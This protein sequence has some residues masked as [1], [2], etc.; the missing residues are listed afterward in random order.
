[1]SDLAQVSEQETS[2]EIDTHPSVAPSLGA[3]LSAARKEKNW[4]VEY[5]ADHL[6][7]S[8]KQIVSIE[9]DNFAQL[10]T[11]VIVRGFIRSYAKMLKLDVEQLLVMLPGDG[12]SVAMDVPLRPKLSTP[13]VESRSN[14]LGRDEHNRLYTLGIIAIALVL[15]VF[16]AWFYQVQ[17]KAKINE[18]FPALGIESAASLAKVDE[19]AL[20]DNLSKLDTNAQQNAQQNSQL[21][22][23]LGASASSSSV[24]NSVASSLPAVAL[25]SGASAPLESIASRASDKITPASTPASTAPLAPAV[26]QVASNVVNNV[27][28]NT[29]SKSLATEAQNVGNTGDAINSASGVLSLKV[30]QDSWLQVK[31]EKGVILFSRLAK[32][33]TQESFPLNVP[34]LVKIGNAAGVQ[35]QVRG[36]VLPLKPEGGTNVVNLLVK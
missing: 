10:P 27:A 7:L 29:A 22:S 18:V 14:L 26:A 3:V 12:K 34:V 15:L 32:A 25:S 1:M 31:T 2:P 13:F 19:L 4:T 24:V 36:E 33:G 23:Q 21:G 9:A 20:P 8:N 35:V 11:M 16:F 6:K 17:I 28:S 30:I 5:V